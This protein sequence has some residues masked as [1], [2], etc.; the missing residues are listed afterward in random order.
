MNVQVDLG[1]IMTTLVGAIVAYFVKENTSEKKELKNSIQTLREQVLVLQ[2]QIK[3]LENA[4]NKTPI[5]EKSQEKMQ[6]DLNIYFRGLKRINE[7]LGIKEI[8]DIEM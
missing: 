4:V 1:A 6:K 8:D 5:L 7:K 3:P 2:T